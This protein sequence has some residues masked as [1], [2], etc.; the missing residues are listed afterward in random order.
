MQYNHYFLGGF[1]ILYIS[2]DYVIKY[3]KERK[4]YYITK[5]KNNTPKLIQIQQNKQL[6]LLIRKNKLYKLKYD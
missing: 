2:L 6:E 4:E 5:I 3:E 1:G